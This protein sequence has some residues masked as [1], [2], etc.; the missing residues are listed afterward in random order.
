MTETVVV[1][2][3]DDEANFAEEGLDPDDITVLIII[4]INLDD[5]GAL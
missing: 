3:K 4:L 1:D 5:Y 2:K